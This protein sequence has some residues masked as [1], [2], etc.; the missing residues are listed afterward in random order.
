MV[1]LCIILGLEVLGTLVKALDPEQG[2]YSFVKG[3]LVDDHVDRVCVRVILSGRILV[4]P[5][6]CQKK[7]PS[8]KHSAKLHV[9]S[10]A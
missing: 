2:A 4:L 10:K 6:R 1:L 3:E 5:I 9:S 8:R 7:S